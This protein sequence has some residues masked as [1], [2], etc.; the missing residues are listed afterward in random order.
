MKYPS[1]TWDT[2]EQSINVA[3]IGRPGKA[4]RTRTD[5]TLGEQTLRKE[6]IHQHTQKLKTLEAAPKEGEDS[7]KSPPSTPD[8]KCWKKEPDDRHAQEDG[9]RVDTLSQTTN[10]PLGQSGLCLL[11]DWECVNGVLRYRPTAMYKR[12]HPLSSA[13]RM[14]QGS[15][16]IKE[17]GTSRPTNHTEVTSTLETEPISS[18]QANKGAGDAQ[19]KPLQLQITFRRND[20]TVKEKMTMAQIVTNLGPSQR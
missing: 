5:R 2:I 7:N 17:E 11:D 8:G 16:Q 10:P 14:V 9:E 4:D 3:P 6:P 13:G 18:I 20:M 12:D 19:S 15:T 1:Q